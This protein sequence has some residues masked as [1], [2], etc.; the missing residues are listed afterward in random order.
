[1]N[2]LS[3][4]DFFYFLRELFKVNA[5]H[6]KISFALILCTAIILDG[7]VNNFRSECDCE[8]ITQIIFGAFPSFIAAYFVPL[9]FLA[10]L[11]FKDALKN[12]L[13]MTAGFLI[14]EFAQLFIIDTY[15]DIY[16][17]ISTLLGFLLFY[18]TFSALKITNRLRKEKQA[19]S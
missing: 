15:F 11:G 1:M 3:L 6:K 14:Y 12:A 16:D 5:V 13:A 8:S 10:L 4:R 17:V 2:K 18:F 7:F 9:A 19:L